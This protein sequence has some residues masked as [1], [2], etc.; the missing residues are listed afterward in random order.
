M[1]RL[2]KEKKKFMRLDG[3]RGN[4]FVY[5]VAE[6]GNA[7]DACTNEKISRVLQSCELRACQS[8]SL[9]VAAPSQLV[10]L[11][12]LQAA[13]KLA[14]KNKDRRLDGRKGKSSPDFMV[15]GWLDF[16]GDS[17]RAV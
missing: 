16:Q 6:L 1:G 9:G 2:L 7:D 13:G 15:Q 8:G 5:M 3:W 14:G 11:C 10:A 17:I 12:T 4:I